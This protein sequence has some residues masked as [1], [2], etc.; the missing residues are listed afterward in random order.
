MCHGLPTSS[1]SNNCDY[2]RLTSIGDGF[3]QCK[4]LNKISNCFVFE[5]CDQCIGCS[6]N[7]I[8]GS[9][10]LTNQNQNPPIFDICYDSVCSS[11]IF[12]TTITLSGSQVT[13]CKLCS[14]FV[15]ICVECNE[16]SCLKCNPASNYKLL[17]A[18]VTVALSQLFKSAF[19]R[20]R[21]QSK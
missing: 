6:P 13:I 14:T 16:T 21:D 18:P 17:D 9:T 10:T 7:K 19:N 2:A 15:V 4:L 20:V 12:M 5:K 11:W 8:H 1:T 3:D